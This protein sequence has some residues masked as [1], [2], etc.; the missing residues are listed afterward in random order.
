MDIVT[1]IH[2]PSTVTDPF[3]AKSVMESL[4]QA[5]FV[6]KKIHI[7]PEEMAVFFLVLGGELLVWEDSNG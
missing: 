5:I 3:L 1:T 4:R 6:Q 2:D 7:K